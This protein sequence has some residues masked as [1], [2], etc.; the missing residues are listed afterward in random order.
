M[1]KDAK[2][3][4]EKLKIYDDANV[5]GVFIQGLEEIAVKDTKDALGLL[6]KGS[7]RL[8]IK[9]SNSM[10]DGLLRV[11]ELNLVDL[12][13]SENTERAGLKTSALERQE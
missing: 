1:G 6:I 3:S 10:G 5:R 7:E 8:P 4:E 12:A 9:D 2:S 11:G 13:G